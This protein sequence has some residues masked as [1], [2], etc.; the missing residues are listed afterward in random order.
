M[1][2]KTHFYSKTAD[3]INAA[4]RME[5]NYWKNNKKKLLRSQEII[6]WKIINVKEEV[7]A[8]LY[9]CSIHQREH[10][11]IY[12]QYIAF[13]YFI[14]NKINKKNF[15]FFS[16]LEKRN[17]TK[18]Y[19]LPCAFFFLFLG[20]M[21]D[22]PLVFL[23]TLGISALLSKS[24]LRFRLFFAFFCWSD[25]CCCCCGWSWSW[26]IFSIELFFPVLLSSKNFYFILFLKWMES[27]IIHLAQT[28]DCQFKMIP[29]H[30]QHHNIILFFFGS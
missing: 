14:F 18:I 27:N 6:M 24:K 15:S 20:A 7:Y 26:S 8:V 23:L 16:I 9:V 25:C 29:S 17:K 22:C 30:E 12:S 11:E 13:L 28:F 3:H 4:A 2:T 10:P 5:W 1:Y 19:Y 21:S